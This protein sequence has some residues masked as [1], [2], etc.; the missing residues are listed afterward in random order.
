[1]AHHTNPE[2]L[3]NVLQLLTEQG[4][5]GFAEGLRLPVNEAMRVERHAVSS[6]PNPTSAPPPAKAAPTA[7]SPRPSPA[8]S[9][10]SPSVCHQSAA[11]PGHRGSSRP[12]TF[13][14]F[15]P[16]YEAQPG[17][18]A[19]A[20]GLAPPDRRP[21]KTAPFLHHF[22]TASPFHSGAVLSR[23]RKLV[24]PPAHPVPPEVA[25]GSAGF[26]P[27]RRTT[28]RRVSM[29][30][31]APS[32]RTVQWRERRAPAPPTTSGCAAAISRSATSIPRWPVL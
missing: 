5:D 7:T 12:D 16:F 14:L 20:A 11:E 10:P 17:D 18:Q 22:C 8:A 4:H 15:V 6:R 27:L 2:L 21:G 32:S 24:Q 13:V 28:V 26:S 31:R 9:A 25:D 23:P 19:E 29:R 3:N 1:M 30:S